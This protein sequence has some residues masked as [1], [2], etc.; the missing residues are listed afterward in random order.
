MI[1]PYCHP[2]ARLKAPTV[3]DPGIHCQTLNRMKQ[4]A[5]YILTNKERGTLY[6]GVTSDLIRRIHQHR[7]NQV[8]GFSKNYHTHK[9]VY[10]ELCG[11][12]YEAIK[13]EKQLKKWKRLWKL[14]LIEKSNPSWK[15]LYG[16]IVG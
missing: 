7:T 1:K 11:N 3:G 2:R 15:D 10:F 6:V 14:E 9:L 4:P 12:M 13:R 16:E 5:V 8:E